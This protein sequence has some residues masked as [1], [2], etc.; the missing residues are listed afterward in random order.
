MQHAARGDRP[1]GGAGEHPRAAS[2]FLSL[3]FQDVYR[4]LC[5]RQGTV[6]VFRF[7]G[8]L[9]HLAVDPGDLP[10]NPEVAPLQINVLPF[11][12]EKFSPAEPSSQFQIVEL[13]HAAVLGLS[14]EGLELLHQQ[15]FHLLV[16]QPGQGTALRRI[17]GDQFLLPG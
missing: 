11:Q 5:Q 4:I 10:P 13:K 12:A 14:Q 8:C 17:C 9:H 15:G 3:C 16:L 1:A 6:G 2:C 7:Q